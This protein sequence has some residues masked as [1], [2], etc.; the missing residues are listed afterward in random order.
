MYTVSTNS[1]LCINRQIAER[2]QSYLHYEREAGAYTNAVAQNQLEVNNNKIGAGANG[3]SFHLVSAFEKSKAAWDE[4]NFGSAN[5]RTDL[6]SK[7]DSAISDAGK[8]ARLD[9]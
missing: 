6:M 3:S 9:L 8:S 1:E 2:R 7:L 5:N 4:A